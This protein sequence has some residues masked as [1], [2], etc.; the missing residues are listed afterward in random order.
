[1]YVDIFFDRKAN[2]M[3]VSERVNGQRVEKN[4]QTNLFFYYED[5]Q[6]PH[7]STTGVRCSKHLANNIDAYKKEVETFRRSGRKTFESDIK[8]EFKTLEEHYKGASLPELRI[9][10]F[11]IETDFDPARGFSSPAEAFLPITAI[12]IRL[13]WTNKTHTL[14][15][16]PKLLQNEEAEL[17]VAKFENTILCESESQLLD[18]FMHLVEDADVMTG[19]NSSAFDIPYIVHRIQKVRGKQDLSRLCL[20]RQMPKKRT[21]EQYGDELTTYDF[22]GRIHLDYLELYRKYTYHELPSYRLDYVGQIE[23]NEN[24]V[25]YSGTLDELYNNDFEKF[26]AYSRQDVDLLYKIDHKNKF[27]NLVNFIAHENIVN[28]NTVGGAVALSDN[29]IL[30]EVHSRGM[31]S[32]EKDR[33][34]EGL[35]TSIAGAF[36]KDPDPGMY[37]WVAVVDINSLYP[38]A[39]RALNMSPET[40]VGYIKQDLTSAWFDEN[41]KSLTQKRN[42]LKKI[43]LMLSYGTA[44]LMFLR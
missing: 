26:I 25:A 18:L 5:L 42:D 34:E 30:L 7:L 29:A 36:V 10:F 19:W 16:K 15:L 6:G 39:F 21:F 9:A 4:L 31:V 27:I 32:T 13:S 1:M 33:T 2:L 20:W 8:P 11:D 38:S 41:D 35:E 37:E 22:I 24:K 44:S 17:I 28:F 12:S 43:L 23:V 3:R 40:I 14:V